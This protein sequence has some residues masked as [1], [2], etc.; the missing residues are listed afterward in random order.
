ML[1]S[2]AL[3]HMNTKTVLFKANVGI[4]LRLNYVMAPCKR[5]VKATRHLLCGRC[6]DEGTRG[7]V[8]TAEAARCSNGGKGTGGLCQWSRC[9][10]SR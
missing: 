8:G 6:E 5:Q 3:R 7:G 2:H 1:V 4:K 9:G 10:D